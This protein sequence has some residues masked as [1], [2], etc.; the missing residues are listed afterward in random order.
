MVSDLKWSDWHEAAITSEANETA[1]D[2]LLKH[3]RQGRQQEDLCFGLWTPSNGAERETAIVRDILLPRNGER[4]LHGNVSFEPNYLSRAT[5]AAIRSGQGLVFMHSHPSSG[6]QDMSVPDIRAERDRISDTARATGKPLVGM[7]LGIDGHW[8]ARVWRERARGKTKVISKKVRVLE[9]SRLVI[10][11][12]PKSKGPSRQKQRRTIDTWGEEK[13]RRLEE[14]R[15][16]IVGLGSVGS[17]VAEGLARTGIRELLLIDH[18][19]VEMHNLDRLLNA[20]SRDVGRMKTDVAE[21]SARKA[22]TADNI[23]IINCRRKIHDAAA[24]AAA[25]DCDI[26][27]SCVDSPSARDILNRIAYRDAIPVVDGGVEVRKGPRGG[28]MNA[29][30]WK[31]HVVTPYSECLRCKGQY[32]SS[33]V[34]MELDG[35]LQNPSY[36]KGSKPKPSSGEN[37][38][39]LSLSAASEMLNLTLRLLIAEHWWPSLEGVE[40]NLVTGRTQNRSSACHENCTINK[41]SWVGDLGKQIDYLTSCGFNSRFRFLSRVKNLFRSLIK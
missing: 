6:W 13:Q 16:G 35:S 7:T 11:E 24:Y 14:L 33:D 34:I 3:Y 23:R 39:C 12:R 5:R 28:N 4:H 21:K 18:D 26:L 2:H 32:T 8:S 29:A 27:V 30:R 31:A 40:R 25:R 20:N 9:R 1:C 41:E 15:I 17:I 38:F 22:S 10:W 19:I 37:V 36:I